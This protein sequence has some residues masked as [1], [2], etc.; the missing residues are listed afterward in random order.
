MGGWHGS[1]AGNSI[2][3]KPSAVLR[4]SK[5]LLV[6]QLSAGFHGFSADYAAAFPFVFEADTQNPRTARS[7][8]QHWTRAKGLPAIV[9][10]YSIGFHVND[11]AEE[12]TQ[13]TFMISVLIKFSSYSGQIRISMSKL[14][15]KNVFKE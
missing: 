4:F 5:Y 3:G 14:M 10:T 13:N 2:S 1:A 12:T 6:W 7:A 11:I 15:K 8:G 9:T